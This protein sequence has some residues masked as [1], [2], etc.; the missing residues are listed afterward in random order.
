MWEFLPFSTDQTRTFPAHNVSIG[1]ARNLASEVTGPA[2]PAQNR[3]VQTLTAHG[4]CD[5]QG[6]PDT[7]EIDKLDAPGR[8]IAKNRPR[9]APSLAITPT[10]GWQAWMATQRVTGKHP[11]RSQVSVRHKES[12]PDRLPMPAGPP[13]KPPPGNEKGPGSKPGAFQREPATEGA[14]FISG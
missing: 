4:A 13:K 5:P 10:N 12:A 9:I 6:I 3:C 14:R 8:P 1:F 11:K 2:L 7:V